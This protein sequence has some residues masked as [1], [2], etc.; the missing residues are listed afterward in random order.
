MLHTVAQV[1]GSIVVARVLK[2]QS[3]EFKLDDASMS[4][5]LSGTLADVPMAVNLTLDASAKNSGG[6]GNL[7]FDATTSAPLSMSR[8]LDQLWP[9][10]PAALS[11]FV[12]AV[13]F[14]AMALSYRDKNYTFQ[15]ASGTQ[16]QPFLAL[17]NAINITALSATYVDTS[18][19]AFSMAITVAIPAM[20]ISSTRAQLQSSNNVLTMEVRLASGLW[21]VHARSAGYCCVVQPAGCL[22][23]CMGAGCLL[24]PAWTYG[25]SPGGC[26]PY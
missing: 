16:A 12:G 11:S 4:G 3:V 18:P 20:S 5:N 25:C 17:A 8:L 23:P 13:T 10:R 26:K 15:A 21:P 24:V 2:L 7:S 6:G 14:P 9:Q 22:S 1:S 19:P